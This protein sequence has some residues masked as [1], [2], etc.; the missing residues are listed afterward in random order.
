M[1]R[2]GDCL[3]IL[4]TCLQLLSITF[5]CRKYVC[6]QS[7][8]GYDQCINM[9]LLR[10]ICWATICHETTISTWRFNCNYVVQCLSGNRY[11]YVSTAC[12]NNAVSSSV[13]S[14]IPCILSLTTVTTKVEPFDSSCSPLFVLFSASPLSPLSCKTK[15]YI[16]CCHVMSQVNLS[17][18]KE[19]ST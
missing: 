3:E 15:I 17:H 10:V 19:F 4:D 11:T 18:L 14:C 9:A 6:Q 2:H 5:Q 16:L 1:R 13:H 7:Q 12:F 8:P